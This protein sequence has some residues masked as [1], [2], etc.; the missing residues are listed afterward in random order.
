MLKLLHR[1]FGL[2]PG[3]GTLALRFAKLAIFWAF[4]SS[5]LD[6]LSDGLFLEKIGAERLPAVYLSIALGMIAVSSLVL[7]SLKSTSPYRILTTAM[8]L[9][10]LVCVGSA[11]LIGCSPPNWFWVCLKIASRMFFAVMI[12]CSWT[13]TDQYHD[14]QDAKRVYSIYSA[15]YFF[16]TILSGTAIHLFLDKIGFSALL[17]A[18]AASIGCGMYEARKIALKAKAVH[19]DTMEGVFSGS[20]D[21]F[22]SVVRL[23][24]RSKFALVLLLMSLFVQ[25]LITV[26]EFNYME[27]FGRFF[28]TS[29]TLV[30]EGE[31]AVFLGKC[32][33][34]ISCCNIFFGIFF[35]SRFVRRMGL[36]NVI[37]ITPLFFIGVYSGW[38][39]HDAMWL[40]ILGLVAVDGILF[41]VEDN[42]FNLLSN[43]VPTKLKSKVRIINDSFFEPIGMLLSALLLFAI[44]EQSRLLG[45]I[46]TA[47]FVVLALI[48]RAIY[49]K[50]IILNLKDNALHFERRLKGWLA[51]FTRRESKESKKDILE[52][53]RSPSEETQLL[54]IEALLQ[55]GESL[56]QIL[57]VARRFGT[58]SK[59]HFLR[60][61]ESSPVT[62]DSRVIELVDSWTNENES[63]ELAKW[64]YLYLAKKGL[65][66]PEKAEDDLDDPDLFLRGAAILTMKKSLAN[67]SLD[68]AALN[69]TIAA[70]KLDLMLKSTRIDEISM[71]LDILAE[72]NTIESIER[73]LPYLSHEAIVVK[74]AAA[75]CIARLADK[76]LARH[77]PS[78]IE[79][80]ESARDNVFR[81]SILDALGK[82]ADSTTT[83]DILLASVHFRPNERRKTEEIL[84]QM[85]L[86]IVPLL[87]TLTKDIALPER[88]RLLAGKILGRLA[89][90]QL[91]ANLIDILDIEIE[92]AYFYFYFGH[93]IQHQYPLY[94]LEMLQSALLSGYQSV[95]DFIIHLLGAAGSLEDPELLVRALH[96]RNEKVH[97]HAVESLEKTC[98]VRIFKLIA[99]LVDDLP[100]EE[101]MA[102]CLR[103]Q[104]DYPKLS[105]SELLG[106]MEQSPTL[107]DRIVAVR[108]KAKLQMPNWREQLREQMKHSDESFHQFAY[109][110]LET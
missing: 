13:F 93:T 62:L 59:I 55:L 44:S 36:N 83:K 109:E 104:G 10:A 53:L 23:I 63:P 29:G 18:A 57:S 95:I 32:R 30:G 80:L 96:S 40:A 20:R 60:L 1:A 6:T 61:L 69:R 16:G 49:S 73:A 28:K 8:A 87:L 91:Q 64:A 90:P 3:E 71:G 86:K 106:K 75:R 51:S 65:H 100:L 77:A 89:L 26:T 82:I 78:L 11:I 24:T 110:L 74:R 27:S 17:F 45:L 43:A 42:C 4:G 22:A 108:L 7:Y 39:F 79:E 58:V 48:I 50:A 84:V 31:I 56:P 81:L 101:K 105:L 38:V 92:R 66:H 76:R 19:D 98:D 52:A 107:F 85:G 54:A 34:L 41:T 97:S 88:A 46:L 2:Y 67:Q 21:S 68:Y 33:A 94:D 9:G 12:A 103:W 72:E 25:L 14:L 99:P 5:C 70:K 35:Y 37:L 47:I 15:A 102:A